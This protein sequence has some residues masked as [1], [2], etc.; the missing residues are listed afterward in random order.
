MNEGKRTGVVAE[1]R[2]HERLPVALPVTLR[3]EGR[4]IPAT[5]LNVS[6]GGMLL[7]A[8]L[9]GFVHGSPVEVIVD[10][11]AVERDVS[12]R[13]TIARAEILDHVTR[14]GIRFTNLFAVGHDALTR[15]LGRKKR[16]DH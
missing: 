14:V 13:G 4:L 1:R 11:S 3:Y 10:L 8:S 5:A 7:D 15:Y 2:T 16:R 12:L 6:C 9:V